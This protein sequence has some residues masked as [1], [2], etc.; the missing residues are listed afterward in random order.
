MSVPES[1]FEKY[2][3]RKFSEVV[4]Q[5]RAIQAL[6]VIRKRTGGLGG[7]AYFIAGKPGT[8]K[9][10]IAR[11]IAQEVA[12]HSI[13]IHEM[14]AGKADVAFMDWAQKCYRFRPIGANGWAFVLNEV[15]GM[16]KTQIRRLLDVI[17]PAGGL[18]SYVAWVFTTTVAGR[19]SLFGREDDLVAQTDASAFAS[20]CKV[21]PMIAGDLELPYALR[22]QEIA[23]AE[24]LD[25]QPLQ[26]YIQLARKH[27]CNLRF[28]LNDIEIGA[29]LT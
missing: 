14:D 29:M 1:L 20:R 18:P 23:L 24:N 16:N 25:G 10:T 12:G 26:A 11:L 5:D 15:H 19:S 21:L 22:A 9:T 28:M 13:G 3:P 17:E 8:G 4:G 6:D 2:R 7:N 27:D